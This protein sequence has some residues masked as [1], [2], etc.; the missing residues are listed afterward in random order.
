MLRPSPTPRHQLQKEEMRTHKP[1]PPKEEAQVNH[2]RPCGAMVVLWEGNGSMA[3]EEEK[4]G[5]IVY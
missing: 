2:P 4:D 5:Y 1:A 3:V